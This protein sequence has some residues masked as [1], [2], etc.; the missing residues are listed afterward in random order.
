MDVPE[1]LSTLDRMRDLRDNIERAVKNRRTL[2]DWR[3]RVRATLGSYQ[4]PDAELDAAVEATALIYQRISDLADEGRN[5]VWARVIEQA[6]APVNLERVEAIVGN[7]PWIN[8][9]HLPEAWQERSKPQWKEW[10]LWATK[11]KSSGIP[12]SDIASLLLA[13][14]IATY[15]QPGA[16]VGLLVPESF[17]IGDPGNEL[18]RRCVLRSELGTTAVPFRPLAVDD[19]TTVQPFSPDAANR[20]IGIYIQTQRPP[21]WPI[22]KLVWRRAV[23]RQRIAPEWHWTQCKEKLVHQELNIAPVEPRNNMSPWV[24]EGGLGLLPKG[25][26]L[27]TYRWG[28]GFHTRGADGYFTVEILSKEPDEEGVVLVRNCPTKGT[29]T[30]DQEPREGLVE[31]KFLWPLVRG[32]DV[33][34][35]SIRESRLYAILPHDPN[36][37]RRVLSSK[38]LVETG[39]RL[40]DYLDDWRPALLRRS[41]YGKI[42]PSEEYPWGILGPTEHLTRDKPIVLSRYIYPDRKP[43]AAVYRPRTDPKLGFKT[44]CYPNN[45]SNVYATASIEES[46]YLAGWLNSNPIM[47]AI[48]GLASSTTISPA[49]LNRLPI[50]QYDPNNPEHRQIVSIAALCENKEFGGSRE[51]D[52]LVKECA[53]RA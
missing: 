53:I 46:R 10:G 9:K 15:A 29:N 19:W 17:L 48:S 26:H 28:Q 14:C 33:S 25:H 37:L 1:S 6:F 51:L 2:A 18:V 52:R 23:A 16:I 22:P 43:P 42:Q 11:S 4:I 30:K 34:R 24:P 8:W 35:F 12:L 50:P 7:P 49:M 31:A 39:P 27:A 36:D 44:A 41:P 32:R 3:L 21:Q 20:P 45:K 5:G 47:G 40:W 38:A 13:R